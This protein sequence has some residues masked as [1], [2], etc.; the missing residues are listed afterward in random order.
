MTDP[1]AEAVAAERRRAAE[2]VREIVERYGGTTGALVARECLAAVEGGS[3]PDGMAALE[4]AVRTLLMAG[5]RV[6]AVKH[7]RMRT[8]VPLKEALLRVDEI[9]ARECLAAVEGKA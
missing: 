3:T 5:L 4:E 8:G 6:N 9:A 1:I 7:Y 2:A